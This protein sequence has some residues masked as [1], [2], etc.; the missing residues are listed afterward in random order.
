MKKILVAALALCLSGISLAE[1]KIAVVNFQQAIMNTDY[2]QAR[3]AEVEKEESYK[4]NI[5]QV[6]KIQD[7]GI[8]LMEK[9]QKE[10]PTMSATQ[11]KVVETEITQKRED[12]ELVARRVQDIK[13]ALLQT[14]MQDM[15]Q[16]ASQAAKELIDAE[17]I[18]LLL[19]GDPQIILHADTSF[20][21]TAKLT[22]RIN[23]SYNKKKK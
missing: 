12:L 6:K 7:E 23:R 10:A 2:A 4:K 13:D 22:E 20:D 3:I 17:G 1:G 5:E 18:G 11:K 15:G 9:Y 14:V 8:K 21:I 19:N 16:L